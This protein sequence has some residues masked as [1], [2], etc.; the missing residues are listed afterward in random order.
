MEHLL[1]DTGIL[2]ATAFS[3]G[4]FHTLLGPDHYVPFI[5]MSNARRWS[6]TKTLLITLACGIG[7]VGSSIILGFVGIF[8]GVAVFHLEAIESTRGSIAAWLLLGFGL[9]YFIW[10][11][12]K[13]VVNRPHSHIHPH[14]GD[15]LHVHSHTHSGGHVHA[16]REKDANITPWVLFTI[17]I[18]GP[19]E[20]LI[21]LVMYPAATGNLGNVL[22]VAAVFAFATITT[23]LIVVHTISTGV[24]MIPLCGLEEYSHAL[25]G[26][27]IFLSAGAMILL[28]L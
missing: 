21:P 28:G 6:Q 18:L 12:H 20:P 2:M 10:G 15:I 5:A 27:A 7:H 23:M 14:Q 16:H 25:A 26:F 1:S 22:L 17:F 4:L 11:M 3:V 19:C 8:L 9:A 24:S 13:A